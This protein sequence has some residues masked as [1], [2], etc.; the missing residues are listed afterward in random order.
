MLRR[1]DQLALELEVVDIVAT[2]TCLTREREVAISTS[3]WKYPAAA[4]AAGGA[5]C[6]RAAQ[7][8]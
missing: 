1:T 8:L 6:G 3:R 7:R 5:S 4:A 2:M